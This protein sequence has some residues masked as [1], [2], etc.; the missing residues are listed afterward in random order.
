[1]EGPLAKRARATVEG[2]LAKRTARLRGR[3]VGRLLSASETQMPHHTA[4]AARRL[5]VPGSNQLTPALLKNAGAAHGSILATAAHE[6]QTAKAATAWSLR[7]VERV[8]EDRL[9]LGRRQIGR[10]RRRTAQR[11]RR[12]SRH[13]CR[14]VERSL[15]FLTSALQMGRDVSTHFRNQKL[16]DQAIEK[17]KTLDTHSRALFLFA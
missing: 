16:G 5:R 8:V 15:R 17:T 12:E 3:S 7:A 13:G 2:P 6:A 4:E 10:D 11:H 1:M 9:Q 14:E